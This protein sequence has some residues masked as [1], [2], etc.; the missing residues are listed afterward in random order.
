VRTPTPGREQAIRFSSAGAHPVELEGVL[1][2][3]NSDRHP[4]AI[5]CHPHP[6]YGGTMDNGV[7]V[8]IARTLAARGVAALRFNFRGVGRSRG[9]FN[10]GAGETDDA[11][12][13]LAF[14]RAQSGVDSRWLYV[15]GYSFG[16][17]VGLRCAEET[18]EGGITGAVAVA[19]PLLVLPHE[20]L[21]S[22]FTGRKC[23]VVADG[24]Q[25]CPIERLQAFVAALPPPVAVKVVHSAD[26]FLWGHEEEV[27]QLVAGFIVG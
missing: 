21:L 9:R 26:H 4:A 27:G 5:V 7:V 20:G 22:D 12:G 3:P 6:L 2:L 14:L 23:F 1:H 11:R 8:A 25:F 13:A 17:W 24:D 18:E 16:A 19:P 10:G 15:V